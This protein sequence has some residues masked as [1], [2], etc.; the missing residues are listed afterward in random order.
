MIMRPRVDLPEP[1]SPTT[2]S[3]SPSCS[4][5]EMPSAATTSRGGWNQPRLTSERLAQSHDVE[6]RGGLRCGLAVLHARLR[7]RVDQLA[8]VGL[9]RVAQHFLD[10]AVL[11]HLA[12]AQ[13]D[14]AIGDVGDDAE[15]MRD[16]QHAHAALAPEIVDQAEDLALGGDIERGRRLVRD[17]QRGLVRHR[18]RDHD[19]L[20]LASGEFERIAIGKQGRVRQADLGQELLH[21]GFDI[22]G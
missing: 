1:N 20:A 5:S 18:H 21:P 6:Q 7:N 16:E 2:A 9:A 4:V 22:G 19:A 17:Q 15:I 11:D 8:R 10:G 3:V 12:V 13:H 14:D